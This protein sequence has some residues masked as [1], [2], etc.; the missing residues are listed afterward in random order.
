MHLPFCGTMDVWY[1]MNYLRREV[2]THVNGRLEPSAQWHRLRHS[3]LIQ[4][5]G[6]RKLVVET[7]CFVRLVVTLPTVLCVVKQNDH[8]CVGRG[9][10]EH[11]PTDIRSIAT[12][13]CLNLLWNTMHTKASAWFNGDV[14]KFK[15]P[16]LSHVFLVSAGCACFGDAVQLLFQTFSCSD[17]GWRWRHLPDD[18]CLRMDGLTND[19]LFMDDPHGWHG[20]KA[21]T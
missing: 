15:H 3:A 17:A 20:W 18:G 5:F 11:I 16:W 21:A 14:E 10:F 1:E 2:R 8:F 13:T 6:H 12:P 19:I 7:K 4:E 9:V